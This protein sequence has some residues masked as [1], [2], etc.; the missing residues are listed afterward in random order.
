MYMGME[1]CYVG[2]DKHPDINNMPEMPKCMGM[3]VVCVHT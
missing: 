2:T 1:A 3:T